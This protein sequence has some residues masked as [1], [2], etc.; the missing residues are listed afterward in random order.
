MPRALRQR[1]R[2]SQ[3]TQWPGAQA[4]LQLKAWA[5]Q[6][7]LVGQALDGRARQQ[8]CGTKRGGYGEQEPRG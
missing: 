5:A 3:H 4:Y 6:M 7:L 8:V 1:R 2:G